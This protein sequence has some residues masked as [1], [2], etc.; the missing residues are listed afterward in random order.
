VKVD[1]LSPRPDITF[2]RR[3]LKIGEVPPSI[4]TTATNFLDLTGPLDVSRMAAG[5]PEKPAA[6]GRVVLTADA[7]V[8]RL[9][10]RQSAI[11]SLIISGADRFAWETQAR[12]AGIAGK[13]EQP[14]AM[15]THANR[16]LI[17]HVDDD[18]IV[19]L[20]HFASLR[21]LIIEA[22]SGTITATLLDGTTI[23][24]DTNGGQDVLH[25]SVVGHHIEL[26]L[27]TLTPGK[28]VAETFQIG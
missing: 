19:G 14:P 21:R 8:V 7:P 27:E 17:E 16:P 15:P 3:R 23:V 22:S 10:A 4:T 28:N 1:L 2:L 12:A 25:L 20:R 26:R 5:V 18:L 11:G 6:A 13:G 9:S 24:A